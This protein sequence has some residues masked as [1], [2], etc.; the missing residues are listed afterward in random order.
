M[1]ADPEAYEGETLADPLEGVSYGRCK[2]K[3]MRRDDGTPW[4][5][6]FAHGRTIYQLKHDAA[7]VH[8]ILNA[9]SQHDVI[10]T[11]IDHILTADLDAVETEKLIA[12]AAHQTNTGI[13]AIKNML[14]AAR[15]AQAEWE[16]EQRRRQ[17]QA[18]RSDPRPVVNAPAAD[19]PWLPEMRI[20][21]E[22]LHAVTDAIPPSRH[23]DD[24]LNCA[25]CTVFPG[26]HA[27]SSDDKD[28][29][30]APQWHI[31]KLNEHEAADLLEKHIDFI[32]PQDGRS[33]QCPTRF[34]NHYRGWNGG[35]LPKLV[36]ISTLPL[37]LGNGEILAPRGLDQ[38]RGIAFIID[39][40]LREHLPRVRND[41]KV[42]EA[43]L[44]AG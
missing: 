16:E 28:E 17:R 4:I 3:I 29:P 21:D 15:E 8:A 44:A 38:L 6:S 18:A 33:V 25:R 13:R 23:A 40:K 9:T 42:A 27:F 7:A 10:S 37:V 39:E 19:A 20:Y 1:L 22:I 5:H 36:A 43:T 12:A 41:T 11:L 35:T 31:R 26:T 34:V 30:P 24:E 32:D 14:K 2:A